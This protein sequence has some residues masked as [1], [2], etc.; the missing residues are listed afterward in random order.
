MEMAV[1]EIELKIDVERLLAKLKHSR[2][3]RILRK[4]FGIGCNEM[5][6]REIA[7]EEGVSRS[8]ISQIEHHAL[9]ELRNSVRLDYRRYFRHN[10]LEQ[11]WRPSFKDFS[12]LALDQFIGQIGA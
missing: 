2:H 3:E 12:R 5:T 9:F 10:A 11:D 4:L 7:A 1:N 6:Y 8:R